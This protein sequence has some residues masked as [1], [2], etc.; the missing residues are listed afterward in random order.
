MNTHSSAY[1]YASTYDST[2]GWLMWE[3]MHDSDGD[4]EMAQYSRNGR[5][6][7]TFPVPWWV[8]GVEVQCLETLDNGGDIFVAGTESV[9]IYRHADSTWE[10]QPDVPEWSWCKSNYSSWFRK[11]GPRWDRPKMDHIY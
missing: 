2:H 11:Y 9:Y 4:R 7:G 10:K 5:S 1:G 6:F 8:K 3:K